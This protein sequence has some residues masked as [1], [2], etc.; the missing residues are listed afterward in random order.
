MA[1]EVMMKSQHGI[2]CDLFAVGVIAYECLLGSRP[3]TGINKIEIR[4]QVLNKQ[5]RISEL[6]KPVG[7]SDEAID[8]INQLLQRKPSQRLGHDSPGTAKLHQWFKGFDWS[9]LLNGTMKS[10]FEGIPL[11]ENSAYIKTIKQSSTQ[12]NIDEKI[13]LLNND[14]FQKCFND[15]EF[16]KRKS[17]L[18]TTVSS[19]PSSENVSVY[20]AV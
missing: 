8:F 1:P 7:V 10:P 6:E 9:G 12:E 2:A 3:Y 5:A 19:R 4:D 16:D 14:Q 20:E 17:T 11:E 13:S 18:R 15:Y